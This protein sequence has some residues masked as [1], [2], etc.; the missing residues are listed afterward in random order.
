MT[1]ARTPNPS[2]R[3]VL[4]AAA[5]ATVALPAVASLAAGAAADEQPPPLVDTHQHFWDL[6][7]FRL[8][9]LDGAGA[10]LNRDHLMADYLKAAEGLNVR[11]AVY[12]EVAVA[13]EQRVAEADYVV[14][15]CRRGGTPTVAAVIGGSPASDDFAAYI[16]RFKDSPHVKG[17]RESFRRGASTDVKFLK[18][19]RLLGEMGMGFDL[20]LGADLMDEAAVVARACPDTRFILDHCGN[21]NA[22][23]FRAENNDADAKQRRRRWEDGV[24]ALA[25]RP[26]VVCKISGVIEA[27]APDKVTAA[28]VAPIIDHCLDRFGPDRVIFASN[29]PVCNR[30]GS[31]AQWIHLLREVVKRRTETER[32]KL[33]H[34]NAIRIYHLA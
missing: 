34:D 27:A 4:R 19:I 11:R 23:D 9:W 10:E 21:A 8:P 32:H 31:F 13:P 25:D 22:R 7:R 24:A 28:D 6:K 17:V 12:M 16:T 3:Q 29:W 26:N 14:D 2:R 30:G 20:L 15:L 33:L 1:R 5:A 18:G